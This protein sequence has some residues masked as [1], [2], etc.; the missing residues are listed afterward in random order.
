MVRAVLPSPHPALIHPKPTRAV[1]ALEARVTYAGRWRAQLP[2]SHLFHPVGPR[3]LS[4][5]EEA[6]SCGAHVE[7]VRWKRKAPTLNDRARRGG[8]RRHVGRVRTRRA[9]CLWWVSETLT[10]QCRGIRTIKNQRRHGNNLSSFSSVF[11]LQLGLAIRCCVTSPTPPQCVRSCAH[12]CICLFK[13]F[14]SDASVYTSNTPQAFW[15]PKIC[16][17]ACCWMGEMANVMTGNV[18]RC[19]FLVRGR[20]LRAR[21]SFTRSSEQKRRSKTSCSA[22]FTFNQKREVTGRPSEFGNASIELKTTI[23]G[24]QMLSCGNLTWG[25]RSRSTFSPQNQTDLNIWRLL[26]TMTQT[27]VVFTDKCVQL[28]KVHVDKQHSIKLRVSVSRFYVKSIH[29]FLNWNTFH[30]HFNVQGLTV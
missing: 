19:R 30:R 6:P 9:F 21:H 16:G 26:K 25:R 12:V 8:S 4:S 1:K 24:A 28:Q 3:W 13:E 5:S 22:D 18:L 23:L 20:H 2:V 27:W 17:P 14:R 29:L 7:R 10:R 15:K 11:A